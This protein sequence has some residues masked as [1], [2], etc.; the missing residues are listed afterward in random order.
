[1][2]IAIPVVASLVAIVGWA[3]SLA[4]LSG[5]WLILV[6]AVGADFF[7]DWRW[8]FVTTTVV[9]ALL[10]VGAEV[11]EFLSGLMGAKAFGGSR[12]SQVGAFL[13]TLLGGL[14]G[15]VLIPI[16]LVG[17][18]IGVI[19]GGFTGAMVGEVQHQRRANPGG[20]GVQAG[21]KAGFGAMLARILAIVVKATLSTLLIG[22]FIWILWTHLA[23]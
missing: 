3:L 5:T 11:V 17:T 8:D 9:A 22:W 23:A 15:S 10:C 4:G 19:G 18:I 12:R 2:H 13:G 7:F 6:A 14:A 16:P 1:M 21:I 20:E